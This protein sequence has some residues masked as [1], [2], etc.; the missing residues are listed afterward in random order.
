[1][2]HIATLQTYIP[3]KDQLLGLHE[4][5]VPNHIVDPVCQRCA[6]RQAADGVKPIRKGGLVNEFPRQDGGLMFV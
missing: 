3:N 6:N 4:S 1:M 5:H 2:L